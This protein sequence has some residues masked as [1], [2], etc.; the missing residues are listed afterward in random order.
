[1]GPFI[2]IR[3]FAIKQ[4]KLDA[5]RQSLPEFFKTIEAKEPRLLALNAYLNDDGTE[6]TFVHIHPDAASME[7]HEEVAHEPT[8]RIRREFL[9]ATASLQVYGEPSPVM[10]EKERHLAEQGIPLTIKSEH[11]GGFTRLAEPS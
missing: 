4:G 8:E 1:M 2:V 9:D 7:R 5:F 6:A 3:T 10:R 11:L